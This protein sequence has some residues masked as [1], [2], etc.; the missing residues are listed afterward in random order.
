[1]NLFFIHEYGYGQV[2]IDDVGQETELL[3]MLNHSLPILLKFKTVIH[4]SIVSFSI[5][6]FQPHTTGFSLLEKV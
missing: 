3:A 2:A 5:F 1:M 6:L 4:A